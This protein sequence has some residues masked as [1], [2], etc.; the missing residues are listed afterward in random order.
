MGPIALFDKSAVEMMSAD[1]APIFDCLYMTNV[2]PIYLVEVLADLQKVETSGRT[3]SKVVADMARKTPVMHAYPNAHHSA[4]CLRELLGWPIE[5]RRVPALGGARPVRHDGKIGLV[6][7]ESP[8]SQAFARWQRGKFFDVEQQFA[9]L[10]REQLARMPLYQSAEVVRAILAVRDTPR[11]LTQALDIAREAVGGAGQRYRT[12]KLAYALLDLDH[13]FWTEVA[14]RW[15]RV[16]GPDLPT[17]APY[18]AHCLLV[19][20]FFYVA[21]HKGLISPERPSNKTD[22]AYLYYL[23]FAMMFIS[24]DKLHRRTAPLFMRDDQIFQPADELKTDLRALDQ[25]YSS[26]TGGDDE[27]RLVQGRAPR[28]RA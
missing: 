7:E 6:Y 27:G 1:E 18:T 13:R 21:I 24:N 11:D 20:V 3:H 12:L 28:P 4:L 22:M 15:K 25:F 10:W 2:C 17:Y 8:E 26:L 5:M 19:D 9:R 23:P 16:G 14:T